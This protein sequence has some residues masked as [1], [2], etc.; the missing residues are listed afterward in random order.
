MALMYRVRTVFSGTPGSPYLSTQYTAVPNDTP[1][2]VDAQAANTAVGAFWNT[3]DA[4]LING[5]SWATE[6]NVDV[7]SDLGV[8]SATF[9]V[10]PVT[11]VGGVTGVLSPP[12]TQ[13]LIRWGTGQFIGGREVRGRTFIPAIPTSMISGGVPTGTLVTNA[14]TAAS[15]LISSGVV[16]VIWSKA[17]NTFRNVNSGSLWSQFAVL[18]S[19]RD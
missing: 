2:L 15:T 16:P 14:N 12:A 1:A 13:G 17:N 4:S 18:R 6:G 9:G 3:I 7:I 5:L 19:R 11:G 8:L 10:T